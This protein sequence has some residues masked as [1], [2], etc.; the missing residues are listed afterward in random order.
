[1]G[2]LRKRWIDIL[3]ECLRKRDLDI[4]QARRIVHDRS[5]W[6]GFVRSYMKPLGDSPVC[7]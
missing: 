4:I 6:W 7:G 5:E 3:K 1:M 2:R